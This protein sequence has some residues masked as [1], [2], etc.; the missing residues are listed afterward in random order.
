M[1]QPK[2]GGLTPEQLEL[3][4]LHQHEWK[5]FVLSTERI[6]RR[7]ATEAM[8]SAYSLIGEEKPEFVF[9]DSPDMAFR[10]VDTSQPYLGRRIEKKIRKPLRGQV[11]SQL[12]WD[13][14]QDLSSR[15]LP[16]RIV[17]EG[18]LKRLVDEKLQFRKFIPATHWLD[19]AI[20]LDVGASVLDCSF[21][22]HKGDV[23]Q[24][25]LK[26]CGW[27]L[28]YENICMICDRPTKILSDLFDDGEYLHAEGEPA[29][30]FADGFSIWVHHGEAID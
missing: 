15:L 14:I 16:E 2:I 7:K 19:I 1:K 24:A 30:Q 21:D 27:V 9:C 3:I 6:E 23:I 8:Q 12:S 20:L 13:L 26:H 4:T 25:I 10:I 17:L 22:Q 5:N 29:I 28:P 18:Q 11:E